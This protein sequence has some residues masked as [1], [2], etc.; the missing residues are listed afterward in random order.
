M[1]VLY[2]DYA[3]TTPVREEVL[4]SMEPYASETFGNPSSLHRHGRAAAAGL[5][6]ARAE[7]A[8][9]LGARPSEIR[10]VQGGTESD[11]IAIIGST[12]ALSRDNP[13]RPLVAVS[14][15]EHSAVLEAAQYLEDRGEAEVGL[16]EVS[17]DGSV[18]FSD[19][20]RHLAGRAATLSFMWAN[21]ETGL[22]LPVAEATEVGHLHGAV[23]HSDASQAIGKVPVNVTAVPVDLLT[24]TGHKIYG[25]RGMGFLFVRE[26]TELEALHYGGGQERALRP[27][28]E[29]VAAAVGLARAVRLAV[30][31]Q[32]SMVRTLAGLRDRLER[33][34][35]KHIDDVRVNCA[36]GIR[37]PHVSSLGVAGVDGADLL[38]ALDVEGLSVSGGSACHSGAGRGSHVIAALYG[39]ED[40]HATVRFS[41]GRTTSEADVDH[42]VRTASVVVMR[43]RELARA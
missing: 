20:D 22:L 6:S 40:P 19:L 28:T 42:A 2:L 5:E 32:E 9:A 31:E 30:E 7:L 23:V 12:R 34:L 10:F 4:A 16:V 36:D 3:A 15:I 8:E 33:G 26:G 18:D 39:E 17:V 13:D 25:P 11:N 43:L 14:E 38:M 37:A 29:D 21:N 41:L 1:T 35:A 27:G 24:G